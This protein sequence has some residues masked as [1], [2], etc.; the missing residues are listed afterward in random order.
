MNNRHLLKRAVDFMSEAS[1]NETLAKI[2]FQYQDQ[3]W[4]FNPTDNKFHRNDSTC[5]CQ[6]DQITGIG[7]APNVE[8]ITP[9]A[10]PEK[11]KSSS[12][13]PTFGTKSRT[14]Y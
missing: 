14:R 8:A 10:T 7:A 9:E 2:Q 1:V 6:A 4:K 11:E 13:R 5:D 12:E 3:Y